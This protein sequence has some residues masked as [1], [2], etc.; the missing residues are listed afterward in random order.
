MIGQKE[1]QPRLRTCA[2]RLPD[3]S[4]RETVESAIMP[5]KEFSYASFRNVLLHRLKDRGIQGLGCVAAA[6][7]K[8]LALP[9]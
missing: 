8:T 3:R 6:D 4:S 2:F 7:Q 5:D 9:T 1:R